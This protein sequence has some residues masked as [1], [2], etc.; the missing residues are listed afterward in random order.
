[1]IVVRPCRS[2]PLG[3]VGGSVVAGVT[4]QNTEGPEVGMKSGILDRK[5]VSVFARFIVV[6]VPVTCR[7]DKRGPRYPI[8]PVTVLDHAGS[9]FLSTK[10]GKIFIE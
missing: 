2:R 4:V 10:L 9:V 6:G 5:D 3:N 1:M 7:S 8:F